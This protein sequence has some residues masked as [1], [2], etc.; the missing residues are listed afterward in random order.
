MRGNATLAA[1]VERCVGEI[2]AKCRQVTVAGVDFVIQN[3]R[4]LFVR[5]VTRTR[6][7][8]LVRTAHLTQ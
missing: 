6:N 1:G 8:W 7:N 3:D 4:R 5:R 2:L